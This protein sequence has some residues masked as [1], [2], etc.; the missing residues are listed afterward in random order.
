MS[1]DAS[2]PLQSQIETAISEKTALCIRGGNSKHFYGNA[3]SADTLDTTNHQGII[4]YQPSELVITAR[5]GTSLVEIETELQKNHQHLP[6]DPP[7]FGSN[8]TLGGT[9]ACGLSGSARPFSGSVRD[10]VLG[11]RIINGHAEILRFGGEVVKN[12]AGYDASRLMTGSLGTLGLLLDISVKVLPAA[13]KKIT[14]I[15]EVTP[16]NVAT[17]M[18]KLR[19]STLPLSSLAFYH[20]QL[21]I[22]V[23]GTEIS[24]ASTDAR[25]GPHTLDNDIPFWTSLKEQTHAFFQGKK[26]LWQLLVPPAT[27][28]T[29]LAQSSF[30]D[31]AGGL[32]WFYSDKPYAEI[33]AQAKKLN[34]HAILFRRNESNKDDSFLEPNADMLALKKNIKRAFDPHNIFNP[35][36]M[37]SAI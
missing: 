31:W 24:L 4:N 7:H 30:I 29:E 5:A 28:N 19:R 27:H 17:A 13:S 3:I 25:L 1:Q 14:Y 33:Q 9:I 12:V 36:K 34:G 11:C 16:E 18:N 32:Y 23:E 20:N 37:Y 35:G 8:A 10:A 15:Q 21:Y 6:F 22:R 2:I 26:N